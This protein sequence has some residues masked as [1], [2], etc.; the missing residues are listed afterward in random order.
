VERLTYGHIPVK[1][2]GHE[3]HHLHTTNEVDEEDLSDTT[4]KGDDLVLSEKVINHLGRSDRQ[5]PKSMKE[6]LANRKYIG[7]CK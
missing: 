4:P 1:G 7:E 6:R 2:H 5:T 3:Q